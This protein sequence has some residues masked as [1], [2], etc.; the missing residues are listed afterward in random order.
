MGASSLRASCLLAFTA[1]S[2][3][4]V[5]RACWVMVVLLYCFTAVQNLV[6]HAKFGE[7]C[8]PLRFV[9]AFVVSGMLVAAASLHVRQRPAAPSHSCT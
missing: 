3:L 9:F 4:G 5:A 6:R 7:A 2:M 8:P 1:R